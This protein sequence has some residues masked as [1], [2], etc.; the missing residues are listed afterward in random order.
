M[1]QVR[2]P[3]AMPA[4]E[5]IY[6][7]MRTLFKKAAL[8]SECCIVCLIYVERCVGHVYVF[9]CGVVSVWVLWEDWVGVGVDSAEGPRQHVSLHTPH[10]T[11]SRQTP[12]NRL[13]ERAHVPLVAVTWRP[14]VL[15]GLLLASKA[16][17]ACT[18]ADANSLHFVCACAPDAG[19]PTNLTLH[20]TSQSMLF[21]AGVAGSEL[22]ERRV[23]QHLPTGRTPLTHVLCVLR[24]VF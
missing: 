20:N 23:R 17:A 18:C 12:N 8:S 13:M 9:G 4:L 19:L 11:P 21:H 22:L 14:V 6:L 7:F 3:C 1:K 24:V 16:R 5:E 15:C 10:H 2:A